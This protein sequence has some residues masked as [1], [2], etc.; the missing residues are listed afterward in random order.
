MKAEVEAQ[1][2]TERSMA[3]GLESGLHG[4]KMY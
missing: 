4:I 2:R 1:E 3:L